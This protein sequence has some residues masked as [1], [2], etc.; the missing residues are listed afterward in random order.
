MPSDMNGNGVRALQYVFY[1]FLALV[2]ACRHEW[3][4]S[5]DAPKLSYYFMALV[6]DNRPEWIGSIRAPKRWNT[7]VLGVIFWWIYWAV[8]QQTHD[9]TYPLTQRLKVSLIIYI[10]SN[11]GLAVYDPTTATHNAIES[12]FYYLYLQYC[13]DGGPWPTRIMC[14]I[15]MNLLC[16]TAAA[17]VMKPTR[18]LCDILMILLCCSAAVS[19]LK[20]CAFYIFFFSFE[21]F[22]KFG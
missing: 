21:K 12:E 9:E 1:Y 17:P 15:L 20:V 16:C 10:W 19:R 6:C 18:I 4:W 22:W 3:I 8:L 7:H 13:W 14:D 11:D 5:S 2:G